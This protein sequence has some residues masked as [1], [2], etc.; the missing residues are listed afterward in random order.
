MM[1]FSIKSGISTANQGANWKI[2]KK[3][4]EMEV[5]WQYEYNTYII[6][7]KHVCKNFKYIHA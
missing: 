2:N 1:P 5:N 4:D 6:I 7:R 3:N